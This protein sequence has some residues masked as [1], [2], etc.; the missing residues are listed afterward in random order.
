MAS[1]WLL[2][3]CAT[4]CDEETG[5]HLAS[6]SS[7]VRLAS[8]IM[9]ALHISHSSPER[10]SEQKNESRLSCLHETP[11][12][13]RERESNAGL[14]L[15]E[16]STGTS[17]MAAPDWPTRA[18]QVVAELTKGL[19]RVERGPRHAAPH[20]GLQAGLEVAPRRAVA[21][22]ALPDVVR[23]DLELDLGGER[24]LLPPVREGV[25]LEV[26]LEEDEELVRVVLAEVPVLEVELRGLPVFVDHRRLNP[27][28]SLAESSTDTQ[29]AM[30]SHW[31]SG[32]ATICAGQMGLLHECRAARAR[33]PWCTS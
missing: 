25:L 10:F 1:D 33:P 15:A 12:H 24:E 23:R 32:C 9:L 13:P 4:V 22:R 29:M 11:R 27:A 28:L 7:S 16:F 31:L 20:R 3:G 18:S 8:E 17:Q 26:L 6:F 21:P 5:L 19:Q 14:S 2:S 30:A